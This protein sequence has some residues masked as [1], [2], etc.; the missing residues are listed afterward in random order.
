MK[1]V[2]FMRAPW[3]HF[4]RSTLYTVYTSMAAS[5]WHLPHTPTPSRLFCQVSLFSGLHTAALPCPLQLFLLR[6]YFDQHE[7]D[8]WLVCG[9][10]QPRLLRH[11]SSIGDAQQAQFWSFRALTCSS[12]SPGHVESDHRHGIIQVV[13]TRYYR[14]PNGHLLARPSP[15]HRVKVAR[16][17]RLEIHP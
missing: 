2:S 14:M 13:A 15:R 6:P 10:F 11:Q 3:P 12:T 8:N 4:F 5:P 17:A 1:H 9:N 16:L 7:A